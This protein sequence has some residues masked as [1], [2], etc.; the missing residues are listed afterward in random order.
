[1]L[2][3]ILK[4]DFCHEDDR[5]SLVQLVHE[6]YKQI[7]VIQSKKSVVRGG[8]YHKLNYEAFYIVSGSCEVHFAK[9][10]VEETNVFST[11]DFFKIDP[12]VSHTFNYLE[13]TIMVGLYDMGV[14]LAGGKKD[15]YLMD[16]I[17]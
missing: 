5:G 3:K 14:E 6:G 7:N 1:M 2:Y 12:Y 8:H 10:R 9:N 11:G 17:E 16:S 15:I 13:D 4:T